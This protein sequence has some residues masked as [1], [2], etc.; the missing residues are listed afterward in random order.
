MI[1]AFYSFPPAMHT[2]L[3]EF[4]EGSLLRPIL[5]ELQH[6]QNLS[7]SQKKKDLFDGNTHTVERKDVF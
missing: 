5:Q 6:S 3:L 4:F 2:M 1:P 7:P